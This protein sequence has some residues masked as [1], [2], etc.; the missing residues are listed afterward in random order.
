L[1]PS[2]FTK[3]LKGLVDLDEVNARI[4][5]SLREEVEG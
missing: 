1:T 4:L 2:D 5:E 3:Y